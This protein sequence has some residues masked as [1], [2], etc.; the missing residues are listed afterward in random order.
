MMASATRMSLKPLYGGFQ[1]SNSWNT[2]RVVSNQSIAENLDAH[3]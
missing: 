3:I 1:L 2:E